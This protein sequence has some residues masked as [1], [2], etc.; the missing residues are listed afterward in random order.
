MQNKKTYITF[1]LVILLVGIA[2]FIGG[3]ML[4]G[5]SV[6]PAGVL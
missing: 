6:P 5:K 4:N 2:A 3:Q 1:G